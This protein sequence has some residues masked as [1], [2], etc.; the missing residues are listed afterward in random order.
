[1][2]NKQYFNNLLIGGLN[3][4]EIKY[5]S[6]PIMECQFHSTLRFTQIGAI[7]GFVIGEV[8]G[9]YRGKKYKTGLLKTSALLSAKK[10]SNW[11]F[12]MCILSFPASFGYY[13]IK[14]YEYTDFYDRAFRLRSNKYQIRID[15]ACI[16]GAIFGG[17]LL[18]KKKRFWD[19]VAL[20]MVNGTFCMTIYN[21]LTWRNEQ[22]QLFE[23]Y[24]LE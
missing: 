3:E 1:M 8:I 9:L 5:I 19:G 13:K 11:M 23:K 12:G 6:S 24:K 20:G 4:S 7:C 14:N 16:Y 2:V 15:N 21:V 18:Y 10:S 17:L 22:Q